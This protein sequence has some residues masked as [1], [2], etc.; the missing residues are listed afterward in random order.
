M[1]ILRPATTDDLPEILQIHNDAIATTTAI[2][3]EEQ[4]D[5]A[6]RRAWFE[7][8]E[9][10]GHPV[11]VADVDGQV[12]GYAAYGAFRPRASYR[13]TVEDSVYVHP[14]H[15]RRGLARLLLT[16]LVEVARA[17]DDVHVV[18]ALIESGNAVSIALHEELGFTVAGSMPEVGRKFERW[19]DLTIL[20]LGVG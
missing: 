8:K 20:Q 6:D 2:W 15:R 18:L 14:D 10:A 3:D 19:L 1:V 11:I 13:H 5:L 9:A 17:D 16:E 7:A 4:V 12:G